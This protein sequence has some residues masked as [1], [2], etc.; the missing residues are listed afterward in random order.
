MKLCKINL[1][2]A[3]AVVALL[4]TASSVQAEGST[5]LCHEPESPCPLA[6]RAAGVHEVAGVVKWVVGMTTVL[7]LSSL[8][9][10]A[11]EGASLAN[12]LALKTEILTWNSCGTTAAHNNCEVSNIQLPLFDFLREEEGVIFPHVGSA[13]ALGWKLKINCPNVFLICV[14]GGTVEGFQ[15]G[16]PIPETTIKGGYAATEVSMPKIE[17]GGTC[18]ATAKFTATYESLD[19]FWVTA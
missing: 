13:K 18:P 17:G 19:A 16:S 12:P 9:E 10:A 5:A 15:L 7:C 3:T 6:K 1:V 4:A 14:Y 2:I 8:M 11:V